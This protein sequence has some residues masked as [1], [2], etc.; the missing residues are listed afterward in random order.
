[1]LKLIFFLKKIQE[2]LDVKRNSEEDNDRA[3]MAFISENEFP[4]EFTNRILWNILILS[5]QEFEKL[6]D[7][8]PMTMKFI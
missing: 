2:I 7:G 4:V 1:M 3:I 5:K 6:K 8:H